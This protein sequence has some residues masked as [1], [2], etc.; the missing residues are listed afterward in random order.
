MLSLVEISSKAHCHDTLSFTSLP[1][2]VFFVFCAFATPPSYMKFLSYLKLAASSGSVGQTAVLEPG[3][4]SSLSLFQGENSSGG[5]N[6]QHKQEESPPE[7]RSHRSSTGSDASSVSGIVLSANALPFSPSSMSSPELSTPRRM[8]GSG[9][10][11]HKGSQPSTEVIVEI[12]SRHNSQMS[13][14][15]EGTS[16]T[17]SADS[18]REASD[19][20]ASA[21]GSDSCPEEAPSQYNTLVG[22]GL[23]KEVVVNIESSTL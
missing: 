8:S 7:N 1:N 3:M 11:T 4:V 12:L 16:A 5:S 21:G 15:F 2:F 14:S 19:E 6:K 22:S 13:S 17:S 9:T 20:S 18:G 10:S 23:G